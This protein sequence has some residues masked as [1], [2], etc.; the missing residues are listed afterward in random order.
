MRL[1]SVKL[2]VLSLTLACVWAGTLPIPKEPVPRTEDQLAEFA[3]ITAFTESPGEDSNP[4]ARVLTNCFPNWRPSEA[5]EPQ[6]FLKVF[7]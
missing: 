4:I 7:V 3:W 1:W 6:V 5:T 2:T